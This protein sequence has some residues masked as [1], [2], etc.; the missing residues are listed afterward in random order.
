MFQYTCPQFIGSYLC[1]VGCSQDVESEEHKITHE[2]C[3]SFWENELQIFTSTSLLRSALEQQTNPLQPQML[4]FGIVHVCSAAA[5][6]NTN[7][8]GSSTSGFLDIGNIV[9][10]VHRAQ[11]ALVAGQPYTV[12]KRLS[13]VP[14]V[15]RFPHQ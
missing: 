15:T 10:M 11:G 5:R 3:T 9:I 7:Y 1:H 2:I 6:V 8:T 4:S 13:D 12:P 14:I